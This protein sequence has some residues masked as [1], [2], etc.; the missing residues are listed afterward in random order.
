MILDCSNPTNRERIFRIQYWLNTVGIAIGSLVGGFY[1]LN[2]SF[3]FFCMES[4]VTFLSVYITIKY[5][6]EVHVPHITKGNL[7]KNEGIRLKFQQL[8]HHNSLVVKDRI[9][10]MFIIGSVLLYSIEHQLNNYIG[11]QL[12]QKVTHERLMGFRVD[13]SELLGILKFENICLVV[14]G[15]LLI[16]RLI[17]YWNQRIKLLTGVFL[18]SLGYCFLA[19]FQN[20]LYLVFVMVLVTI[21]QLI[22]VP[23]KQTILGNIS[24]DHARGSYMAFHQISTYIGEIFAGVFLIIGSALTNVIAG[25]IFLFFGITSLFLFHHILKIPSVVHRSAA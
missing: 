14:V 25:I 18:Y 13:G 21:G 22:Y 4:A 11:I 24:P 15:T 1:F 16:R 10:M 20:P 6:S 23:I 12:S 2:H 9:F 7:K 19:I 8:V 5:L 17:R 3:V